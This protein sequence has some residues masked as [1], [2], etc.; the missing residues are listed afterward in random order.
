MRK[1]AL[2]LMLATP[3]LFADGPQFVGPEAGK[4]YTEFQNVYYDIKNAPKKSSLIVGTATNDSALA[5]RLG[6]IRSV[7]QSS[8]VN[9]PATGVNGDLTTFS[10]TSGDWLVTGCVT[11]GLNGATMTSAGAGVGTSA[12]DVNPIH[13]IDILP[14]TTGSN[15]SACSTER[16]SLSDTTT[17]RLKYQCTYSAGTPRA[18][19]YLQAWRTR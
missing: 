19:G 13:R 9:C 11:F 2:I 4:T 5:G 3:C 8:F 14:P 7:D 15:N 10:L 16:V 6:E 1:L 17:V 18:Y 12:G